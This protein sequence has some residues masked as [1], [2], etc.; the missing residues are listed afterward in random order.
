MAE[1][2]NPGS[3]RRLVRW[4]TTPPQAYGV[5]LVILVLVYLLSFYAGTLK[6]Q[7]ATDIGPPPVTAPRN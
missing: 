4:A 6:P 5:Y 2:T 3:L 1:E 7:K